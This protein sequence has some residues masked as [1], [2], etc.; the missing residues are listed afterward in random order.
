MDHEKCSN[1]LQSASQG[2]KRTPT[3]AIIAGVKVVTIPLAD[4][5]ELLDCRRRL[6]AVRDKPGHGRKRYMRLSRIERDAEVRTFIDEHLALGTWPVEEIR[7]A[8]VSTFG[9]LRAPSRSALNRY[10]MQARGR[11]AT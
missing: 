11:R 5:A 6:A 10:A 3:V 9:Q 1:G 4:Y 7:A 2:D 8:I